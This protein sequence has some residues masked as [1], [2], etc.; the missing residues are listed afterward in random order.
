M[1]RHTT[2]ADTPTA[3]SA[4]SQKPNTGYSNTNK[5]LPSL[6]GSIGIATQAPNP[7]ARSFVFMSPEPATDTPKQTDRSPRSYL[8]PAPAATPAPAQGHS[9]PAQAQTPG[10]EAD[11]KPE[12]KF[13]PSSKNKRKT[14]NPH[15]ADTHP[16]GK[17]PSR[18]SLLHP[19]SDNKDNQAEE[20]HSPLQK[21]QRH[22]SSPPPRTPPRIHQQRRRSPWEMSPKPNQ[23]PHRG[24]ELA[25]SNDARIYV[26]NFFRTVV[27]SDD[28]K[29]ITF[30]DS[31][32]QLRIFLPYFLQ[33]DTYQRIIM[34]DHMGIDPPK[35]LYLN[36]KKISQQ[37]THANPNSSAYEIIMQ[38]LIEEIIP[39]PVIKLDHTNKSIKTLSTMAKRNYSAN[40]LAVCIKNIA[41]LQAEGTLTLEA[42]KNL[43]QK[44]TT[45]AKNAEIPELHGLI[46]RAT[47]DL[48][49]LTG[50][51]SR[52]SI[53]TCVHEFTRTPISLK[54]FKSTVEI[55]QAIER[56][57]QEGSNKTPQQIALIRK[58]L[59]RELVARELKSM[60]QIPIIC[61][62]I[63]DSIDTLNTD[64]LIKLYRNKVELINTFF[65][66]ALNRY[67]FSNFKASSSYPDK[68][69]DIKNTFGRSL[70]DKSI[71]ENPDPITQET[72]K[73]IKQLAHFDRRHLVPLEK[74]TTDQLKLLYAQFSALFDTATATPHSGTRGKR[75]ISNNTI[76]QREEFLENLTPRCVIKAI[77]ANHA[78]LKKT[79][80]ALNQDTQTHPS[81]K[82]NLLDSANP[83]KTHPDVVDAFQQFE[84]AYTELG[85][86]LF[87]G[88]MLPPTNQHSFDDAAIKKLLTKVFSAFIQFACKALPYASR[89]E[90]FRHLFT[91]TPNPS[92]DDDHFLDQVEIIRMFTTHFYEEHLGR[93]EKAGIGL[94]HSCFNL[95]TN[96]PNHHAGTPIQWQIDTLVRQDAGRSEETLKHKPHHQK[97]MASCERIS[98]LTGILALRTL[99]KTDFRMPSL[100]LP[101]G[102]ERSVYN[103]NPQAPARILPNLPLHA[104]QIPLGTYARHLARRNMAFKRKTGLYI[105]GMIFGFLLIIPGI[106]VTIAYCYK[107]N[108]LKRRE[109]EINTLYIEKEDQ[110]LHTQEDIDKAFKQEG[111]AW[112]QPLSIFAKRRERTR[113]RKTIHRENSGWSPDP[114][115]AIQ[116]F[117]PSREG[118]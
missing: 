42:A 118:G 18:I 69:V 92:I 36:W 22:N 106:I 34:H 94:M 20:N 114:L 4:D 90:T 37:F 25:F 64:A 2:D 8:T 83:P 101:E 75:S 57:V 81:N 1:S 6:D 7:N 55:Q 66:G 53:E 112:S 70:T 104:R 14:Y 93:K 68:Q 9:P 77:S 12:E 26:N 33:V 82:P 63:D 117:A 23:T 99:R 91:Q 47:L 41:D 46:T 100:K 28:H 59:T 51:Q 61:E 67:A 30:F 71:E 15:L 115:K 108:M 60:A 39:D 48:L 54:R 95:K 105:A 65:Q 96:W 38:T 43:A 11:T 27:S 88:R 97:M 73:H 111:S 116:G 113:S 17:R 79:Q 103:T 56:G 24:R 98:A 78:L 44:L 3:T 10:T 89:D 72:L 62:H 32:N 5:K 109:Q 58:S 29:L 76:H 74:E 80:N 31:L 19:P 107:K 21:A 35:M 49:E 110:A 16:R 86:L 84:L 87:G 102:R 50:I 13:A 40:L 52:E 45:D 85:S